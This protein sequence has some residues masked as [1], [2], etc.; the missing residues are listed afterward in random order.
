MFLVLTVHTYWAT[1]WYL[2]RRSLS[3]YNL[4]MTYFWL[5]GIE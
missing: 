3:L 2:L 4:N 1:N 5:G